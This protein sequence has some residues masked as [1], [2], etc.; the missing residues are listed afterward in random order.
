MPLLIEKNK[1]F[2]V[3]INEASCAGGLY[4]EINCEIEQDEQSAIADHIEIKEIQDGTILD[5]SQIKVSNSR[6]YLI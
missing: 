1:P 2:L 4:F 5:I 6:F 3:Q